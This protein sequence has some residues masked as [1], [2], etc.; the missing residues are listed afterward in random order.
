MRRVKILFPD[1]ENSYGQFEMKGDKPTM[2]IGGTV[3]DLETFAATK[4]VVA[5]N[6]EET[7]KIMQRYG[8][9]ARPTGRQ[10]TITIS[11]KESLKD[12]LQYAKS[13]E[14]MSVTEILTEAAEEWLSKREY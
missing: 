1:G 12:R 8:V 10:T 2:Q 5:V 14:R 4:A 3:Y 9:A 6:D 7:L 11:V 13:E